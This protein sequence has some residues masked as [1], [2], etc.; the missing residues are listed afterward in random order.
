MGIGRTNCKR[1]GGTK[2]IMCKDPE[3]VEM[4]TKQ[5]RNTEKE[6]EEFKRK[7][8]MKQ[9]IKHLE[10]VDK[11]VTWLNRSMRE[12]VGG[13][14]NAEWRDELPKK[15]KERVDLMNEVG[16]GANT[17][18]GNM[19]C[20]CGKITQFQKLDTIREMA[21]HGKIYRVRIIG[22]RK[23]PDRYLIK[24]LKGKADKA[25]EKV[26][27]DELIAVSDCPDEW[28]LPEYKRSFGRQSFAN[29]EL[30]TVSCILCTKKFQY[31]EYARSCRACDWDMCV[32]CIN[33]IGKIIRKSGPRRLNESRSHVRVLKA[34]RPSW[35]RR[36][37]DTFPDCSVCV[38]SGR[39]SRCLF[40]Q[41]SCDNCLGIGKLRD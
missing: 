21:Q 19:Q 11:R 34:L 23:N 10:N 27:D 40:F 14:D 13:L 20:G 1:C 3:E 33:N 32:E 15:I 16:Q 28:D 39:T 22:N 8:E 5:L 6:L 7:D 25:D 24:Y 29:H 4:L 12:T 35:H 38:G 2:T 18:I 17:R 26:P 41:Q 9:K 31:G 37:A 30:K 36:L